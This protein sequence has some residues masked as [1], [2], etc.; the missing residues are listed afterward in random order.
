M[1]LSRAGTACARSGSATEPA[2]RFAMEFLLGLMMLAASL[3]L[4]RLSPEPSVVAEA[5]T[6]AEHP[7]AAIEATLDWRRQYT[8]RIDGPE[9]ASFS[10]VSAETYVDAG[11]TPEGSGDRGQQFD[12][13]APYAM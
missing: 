10:A 6:S 3:P 2:R 13:T 1:L 4:G 11:A 12:G 7:V 5:R 9:G 8:I